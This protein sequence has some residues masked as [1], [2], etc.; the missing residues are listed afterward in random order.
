MYY[1][2]FL[3]LVEKLNL[4]TKEIKFLLSTAILRC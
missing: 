4:M 3:E 1:I 2:A